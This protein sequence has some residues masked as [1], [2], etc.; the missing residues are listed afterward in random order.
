MG[1]TYVMSSTAYI[2]N[3][4]WVAPLRYHYVHFS[5]VEKHYL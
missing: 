2:T 1:K 4:Q 5:T 3:D